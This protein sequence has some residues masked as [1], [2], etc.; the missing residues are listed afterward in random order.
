MNEHDIEDSK[1][2]SINWNA[3]ILCQ[4]AKSTPLQ[5][6]ADSK[7]TDVGRGYHTFASN[8]ENF[9]EIGDLPKEIPFIEE[10]NDGSG[11]ESIK[12]N[13]IKSVY[14]LSTLQN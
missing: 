13:C 9:L 14:S 1:Q 5:C 10:L 12:P 8:L 11:I 3:C 7:R 4:S 2:S 6:P